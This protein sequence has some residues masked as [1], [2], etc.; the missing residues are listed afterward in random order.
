MLQ[1]LHPTKSLSELSR[2]LNIDRKNI[3]LILQGKTDPRLSTYEA[4]ANALGYELVLMK[5]KK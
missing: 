5:R 1:Q 2:S 3:R 4:I